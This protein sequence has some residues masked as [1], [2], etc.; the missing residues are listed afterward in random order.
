MIERAVTN[1][2][3]VFAF[4]GELGLL[5]EDAEA[6]VAVWMLAEGGFEFVDDLESKRM[7]HGKLVPP[8]TVKSGRLYGSSSIVRVAG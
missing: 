1:P 7:G 5:C 2:A 8:A 6:G 3:N 4:P